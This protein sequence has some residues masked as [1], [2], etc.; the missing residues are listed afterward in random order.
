MISFQRKMCLS[1]QIFQISPH[2]QHR[3]IQHPLHYRT[4]QILLLGHYHDL[5]QPICLCHL[6]FKWR[7]LRAVCVSWR[8]YN[9]AK[10]AIPTNNGAGEMWFGLLDGAEDGK[11]NGE[12]FAEI[13]EIFAME[14]AFSLERCHL[15]DCSWWRL[16]RGMQ[17]ILVSL[18][19]C[20]RGDIFIISASQ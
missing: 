14:D 7:T 15:S 1:M 3:Y 13:F 19:S 12:G 16:V 9:I 2:K 4:S 17:V 5:R 6:F 10:W 8:I 11:Y 18:E 20:W